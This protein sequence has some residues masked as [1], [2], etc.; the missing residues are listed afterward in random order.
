MVIISKP[1]KPTYDNP[2]SFH[3]IILLNTLSK[4]IEKVT[5]ERLQFHIVKNDFIHPSQLGGLKFKSTTDA[6]IALTHAIRSDWVKNKTTSILA[7]DITQFFPSLNHHLLILSLM[8][9]DLDPK[10]TSF[11][12]DFLIRRKTNYVWNKFSSPMYKVNVGVGQ[13]SALSSILSALYLSSLLYILEKH[14]NILNIPISLISF[15]DDSLFISQNKSIDASNSQLFCSYNVLSRLLNK[16]GLNIEH[17]KT[18][19]FH[20]NRSHGMFNPPPLDLS[21]LGGPILRPKNSWKYLGFIFN[22]KLIFHQYINF[23][24]NKA[25][26]TVKCMKLLGNS[27]REINPIQKCLLYRCCVLPIALYG[28]QLWFYNKAPLLYPMK[29]LRK[30]QRR[31]TIW[32]LGAFKMLSTKGLEAIMGLIPIKLHLYKLTSRSQVCSATLPENHL[33]KTLMDDPL[34]TC[35][36]P[37]PIRLTRLLI[38]RKTL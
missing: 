15:V 7:F 10:V 5:A 27:T 19:M 28:F 9:A 18:K 22:Q 11:F 13:R 30:M 37:P 17:S 34:N 23:Y 21:P 38:A 25:I 26:S 33:I 4:L 14:L 12:E 35:Y 2:K 20:F 24:S 3:P 36:K 1:N 29:I 8:K 32:I 31:A 6:G 16:F